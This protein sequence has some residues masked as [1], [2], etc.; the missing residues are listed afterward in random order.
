MIKALK[1]VVEPHFVVRG[2][3]HGR[4]FPLSKRATH[5]GTVNSGNTEG[6]T[7]VVDNNTSRLSIHAI[8]YFNLKIS[9]PPMGDRFNKE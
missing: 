3:S 6:K 1:I 2:D 9:S 8:I 7:M 5:L 4:R